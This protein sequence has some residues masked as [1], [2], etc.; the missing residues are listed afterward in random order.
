M[1]KI[2]QNKLVELV[3][4]LKYLLGQKCTTLRELQSVIESL[5]IFF[6]RKAIRS[7]RAFNRRFYDLAIH[8]RKLHHFVKLNNETK[9]GY[10]YVALLSQ[11]I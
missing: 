4:K 6:F 5:I 7:S 3:Q 9:D 11:V 2:P 1:I 10:W 8:A